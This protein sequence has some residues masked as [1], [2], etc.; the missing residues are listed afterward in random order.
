[1]I[2][3]GLDPRFKVIMSREAK[4]LR[5]E[6]L[7]DLCLKKLDIKQILDLYI[8]VNWEKA[9]LYAHP[10]EIVTH[11]LRK[12]SS[13][14]IK[15]GNRAKNVD[16]VTYA[17]FDNNL[18]LDVTRRTGGISPVDIDKDIETFTNMYNLFVN[19]FIVDFS[20]K[21]LRTI[22]DYSKK[23]SIEFIKE[24]MA[25]VDAPSNKT[26]EYLGAVIDREFTVREIEL[27]ENREI[28]ESTKRVIKA[29]TGMV[30]SNKP[31]DWEAIDKKASVEVDNIS[32]FDKVKLS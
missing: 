15:S 19:W 16:W 10:N 20:Y 29:I 5:N 31:V 27:M 32:E 23:F 3:E 7:E 30:K 21:A 11:I 12:T 1:M 8:P 22:F 28:L 4:R 2:I 25:L 17:R 18:W 9:V 14:G 13:T 24:C 6:I 26:I